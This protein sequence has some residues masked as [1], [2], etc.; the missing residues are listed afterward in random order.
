MIALSA[1]AGRA[2]WDHLASLGDGVLDTALGV[3][4]VVGVLSVAAAC[5]LAGKRRR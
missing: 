5:G 4:G 2:A 3:V 1:A